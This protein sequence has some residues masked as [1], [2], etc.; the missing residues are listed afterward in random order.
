MKALLS[1][2]RHV[3]RCLG[4][5]VQLLRYVVSFCWTLLRARAAPLPQMAAETLLP[6]TNFGCVA[7]PGQRIRGVKLEDGIGIRPPSMA[8]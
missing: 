3:N 2:L 7:P 1:F 6:A 8:V 4:V 5:L